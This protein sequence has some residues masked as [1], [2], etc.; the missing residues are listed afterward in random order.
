M[1]ILLGTQSKIGAEVRREFDLP[2]SS[3]KAEGAIQ[4]IGVE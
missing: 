2:L 3:L 4:F 1:K